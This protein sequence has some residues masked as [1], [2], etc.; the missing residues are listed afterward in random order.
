MD[1]VKPTIGILF[2]GCSNEYP[3]SLHSAA[4]VMQHVDSERFDVIAIGIDRSGGWHRYD[5]D[6]RSIENDSWIGTG[7]CTPVALPFGKD[8]HG[9][10]DLSSDTLVHLD[11]ALPILH[12]RNGEDGSVQGAL[13]LAGIPVIGCGV[14]GSA[15]CMDKTISHRI[16]VAEGIGVPE[17]ALVDT[18]MSGLDVRHV[19]QRIGY[20]LFVKPPREG[21]SMGLSRVESPDCLARALAGAFAYDSE[22]I[23]ER[24]VNGTE[25]GCAVLESG[26]ALIVGEPDEIKLNGAVFD[27]VEKYS[28]E[29]ADI[30][31]PARIAERDAQRVKRAATRL[32]RAFGCTGFARI[33]FF[34]ANDG[35]LLFNEANT[36]PGFTAHSRFP[37]MLQ[38]AGLPLEEVLT[39]AI[40]GALAAAKETS[41]RCSAWVGVRS[42]AAVG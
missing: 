33:D 34:L 40:E 12:G 8:A 5:G 6:A 9:L 3:V 30:V 22:A 36:I 14:A 20:P 31:V 42:P 10:I 19:A 11:A 37:S 7:R 39:I 18:G 4:A 35:R 38:A 16:A 27:Y 29:V 15:I 24:E 1:A 17:G 26:G 32:F 25:I 13:Q 23:L 28:C 21:S 41:R 2:G